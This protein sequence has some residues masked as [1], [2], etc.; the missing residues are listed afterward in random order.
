MSILQ[1]RL[2][3]AAEDLYT[4]IMIPPAKRPRPAT[5]TD[6]SQ[7]STDDRNAFLRVASIVNKPV[8]EL[9]MDA[10]Q[11]RN[12]TTRAPMDIPRPNDGAT[13]QQDMPQNWQPGMTEGEL[14]SYIPFVPGPW[15]QLDDSLR[16]DDPFN[17]YSYGLGTET[18][19]QASHGN[20]ADQ[21]Y[22]ENFE[23]FE[24]LDLHSW[25]HSTA[26]TWAGRLASP[27]S[28][29]K[30]GTDVQSLPSTQRSQSANQL[31]AG[32]QGYPLEMERPSLGHAVDA[33]DEISSDFLFSSSEDLPDSDGSD[34]HLG[35]DEWEDLHH[36][37]S[38]TS[39]QLASSADTIN[40]SWSLIGMAWEHDTFD[41][42]SLKTG[43]SKPNLQWIDPTSKQNSSRKRRGPFQDK[44]LQEETSETRK[45]KACVRC[46]QQ[47][48]RCLVNPNDPNGVCLTCQAVSKQKIHTL[49]CLR[50]K[51]TECT[52]YR[53]G[54][55][56]G[57]EFTFRW[58]VM[59]LKDISDWANAEV[60]SISIKSD[61]CPTPL[62]VSVR[63]FVPIPQDSLH[64]GWMDGKVKKFKEVTP[65]AIVN[66]SAAVKDMWEHVNTHVFQCMAFFLEG[67]DAFLRET[68]TF[69]RRYMTMAPEEE[70]ILLCNFFRLWFAIRRTA[71]TEHIV[72]ED[73]I[74]MLPETKDIS[75]PLFGKVPLPPIM[76]QQLDMILT[77][78]LLQ[79]LRKRVLEDFHK[80]VIAN[81]PKSWMT[82]YLITFMF[83]H[84]CAA[85]S[86]E[87]YQNA[88][89]HGLR[90]RYAMPTFISELHHASNVLLAH[91]HYCT[92]PCDPFTVDW[93]RRQSTPFAEMTTDEIHFLKQTLELVKERK[94]KFRVANELDL[95]EDD[96]YFV[97]QMF[98]EGWT[99]R[100]TIIDYDDGT[101][102]DVALRRFYKG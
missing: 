45:R 96:L 101:V 35:S 23:L 42:K 53:T 31:T 6:L 88:R 59:K 64:K 91:Y 29:L 7:F 12:T 76:I 54:K 44:Q 102:G 48:T 3:S 84:S 100:D 22:S 55:A 24:P 25:P 72:G 66:M 61:V 8:S 62:I 69:A 15:N 52:P 5:R 26:S 71:T 75:Y 19:G 49:P 37:D 56:P 99:P 4:D 74:D 79:P 57:L 18:F 33:S 92:K 68:Y 78:G 86:A 41:K 16:A 11:D 38:G 87:N 81:K 14:E 2:H 65:F 17:A 90:R 83:A 51:I 94:D 89:K 30:K 28:Q 40:S 1:K 36:Q 21:G 67:R 95:Y 70:K 34:P 58:P 39:T 77:L 27:K 10:S 98:E 85:L 82:I 32:T 50:Y 46:R 47:K 97:S 93:R 9:L 43:N 60:R 20:I 73:T 13:L 63:R 80:I